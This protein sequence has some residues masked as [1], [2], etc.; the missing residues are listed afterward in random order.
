ML[1]Y[2][3]RKDWETG[4]HSYADG[5]LLFAKNSNSSNVDDH[6]GRREKR[7]SQRTVGSGFR[8]NYSMVEIKRNRSED[9][10]GSFA[11]RAE[12]IIYHRR[13]SSAGPNATQC[14]W[15]VWWLNKHSDERPL[16][17]FGSQVLIWSYE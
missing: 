11:T 6:E 7:E 13:T 3:T 5:M 9:G 16:I 2:L 4:I 10:D 17:P 8:T 15:M 1:V 12:I 14:V